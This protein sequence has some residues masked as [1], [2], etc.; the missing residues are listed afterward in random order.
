MLVSVTF[1]LVI[2]NDNKLKLKLNTEQQAYFDR[3]YLSG[4]IESF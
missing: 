2:A 4:G 3:F 1:N